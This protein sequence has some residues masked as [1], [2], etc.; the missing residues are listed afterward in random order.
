MSDKQTINMRN[1]QHQ[2][3]EIR[4]KGH[5]DMKWADWF[6]SL[7]ITLEEDGNTLLTGLVV[8]QS[9]LYSLIKKI[10]DLGIQLI[11]VNQVETNETQPNDLKKEKK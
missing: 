1:Y 5:I 3:Y 11:S 9:A 4:L 7:V 8:D 6:E 2:R 10:R